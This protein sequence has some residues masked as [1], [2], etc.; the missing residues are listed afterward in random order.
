MFIVADLVSLS[1]IDS[2]SL[3]FDGSKGLGRMK[4]LY[5]GQG[6]M[7]F[8][9]GKVKSISYQTKSGHPAWKY[10]NIHP[11]QSAVGSALR[12]G[13]GGGDRRVASPNLTT[14]GATVLCT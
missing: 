14:G 6:K 5:N 12:L 11:W 8:G 3:L 4:A 2:L 1:G 10:N 7:D 13:G 9:Q